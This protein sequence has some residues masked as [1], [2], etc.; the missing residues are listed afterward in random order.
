MKVVVLQSWRL[1]REAAKKR[2]RRERINTPEGNG[3]SEHA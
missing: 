3:Q 2:A 1:K